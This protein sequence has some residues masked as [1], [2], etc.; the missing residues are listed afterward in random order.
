MCKHIPHQTNVV[1][2]RFAL[3]RLLSRVWYEFPLPFLP[4]DPF[5]R[6]VD[7]N[8]KRRG[9]RWKAPTHYVGLR[10]R[11]KS[12]EKTLRIKRNQVPIIPRWIVSPSNAKGMNV[13]YRSQGLSY[14]A[15]RMTGVFDAHRDY[16][17]RFANERSRAWIIHQIEWERS[18]SS[19]S[20]SLQLFQLSVETRCFI[21]LEMCSR[22]NDV[23]CRFLVRVSRA[24]ESITFRVSYLLMRFLIREV[25]RLIGDFEIWD[26]W[27][28]L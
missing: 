17:V 8:R 24:W 3:C 12:N 15:S 28:N 22:S 6:L 19:F 5:F 20:R 23:S 10:R 27:C 25:S 4:V 9:A 26:G 14:V 2:K 21:F 7:S 13:P 18:L 11:A 16:A 1:S